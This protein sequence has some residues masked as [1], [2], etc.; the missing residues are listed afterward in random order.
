MCINFLAKKFPKVVGLD[1]NKKFCF[2]RLSK[3]RLVTLF[4]KLSFCKIPSIS[5]LYFGTLK[6]FNLE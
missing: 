2:R 1:T 6:S 4:G 3:S 5:T